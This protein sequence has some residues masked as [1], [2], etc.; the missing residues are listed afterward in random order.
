MATN[1]NSLVHHTSSNDIASLRSPI[2]LELN[3]SACLCMLYTCDGT[4]GLITGG[5][6]VDKEGMAADAARV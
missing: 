5:C 2:E 4:Q 6:R 1:H 3:T